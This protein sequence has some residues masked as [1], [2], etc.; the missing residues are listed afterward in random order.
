[1]AKT[2]TERVFVLITID[3]ECD[4]DPK[5]V[6][7]SPLGFRSVLEG[8]PERLQ[9]C[10]RAVGAAPTYLLTVEVMENPDCVATLRKLPGPHELGTHLHA[11]FIEP[12]KKFVDY[13][14]VDSPDVQCFCAPD[15]EQKKLE[16]LTRLFRSQFG[17]TPR[18]FRAGRFGAGSTT[19]NSLESLGYLVDTSVT[20]HILW[21]HADGDVDFR[22]ASEQ[23]Y[24]PA[25]ADICGAH[26]GRS[27]LEIPVSIRKT[28]IGRTHWF[29]PWFSTVRE[30][31][32]MAAN[33]LSR[34]RHNKIVVLNMM[35]HSMEV[36]PE[37]SPYPQSESDVQRYL[38]DMLAV[39]AWCK[40]EGMEF[41]TPTQVATAFGLQMAEAGQTPAPPHVATAS[42]GLRPLF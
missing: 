41:A 11:A 2:I 26:S 32:R 21:R 39:L 6:R 20:P 25:P 18:A 4:H 17:Y 30:M 24:F 19:I 31:K 36:I 34:Y 13:A 27:I 38:D 28:W 35:I 29:R 22:R 10:M 33:H 37:A 3:T 9:P 23:P 5:W 16:N 42:S 1:M 8:I 12:E 15:V 40:D 7:S 14:G